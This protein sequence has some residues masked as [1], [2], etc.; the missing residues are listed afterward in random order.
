MAEEELLKLSNGHF[1]VT[2]VRLPNVYGGTRNDYVRKI[3]S[4][5]K[6]LPVIPYAY[7]DIKQS[8]LY[9]DNLAELIKELIINNKGGI[10][11]PQDGEAISSVQLLSAIR[12]A[13]GYKVRYSKALGFVV[14]AFC[15][16]PFV[17]KV[18]GGVAYDAN[19]TR[20]DGI[21]YYVIP[22]EEAINKM[23]K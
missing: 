18:Y 1:N 10:I 7:T 15:F 2:I 20:I 8:T 6:Y 4:L 12:S 9:M 21:D 14:R 11:M 3:A 23:L 17:K 19:I 22:F 5:I 16:L 13:K